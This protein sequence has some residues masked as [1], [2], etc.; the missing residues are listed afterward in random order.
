MDDKRPT[1]SFTQNLLWRLSIVLVTI[2]FLAL[3][4]AEMS[5][6]T[7]RSFNWQPGIITI[8]IHHPLGSQE[9]QHQLANQ[10]MFDAARSTDEIETAPAKDWGLIN[11]RNY[12]VQTT[13]DTTTDHVVATT[14]RITSVSVVV[15]PLAFLAF[16]IV[17]SRLPYLRL[18][19]KVPPRLL[20]SSTLYR[21]A[22][23][24][25]LTLIAIPVFLAMY[26]MLAPHFVS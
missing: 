5:I 18:S 2:F 4:A 23:M 1:H 21:V 26:L 17:W 12:I 9:L 10:P 19:T 13:F 14:A 8:N 7:D 20:G 22:R 16:V 25:L 11:W 15:L 24:A 6:N 3:P